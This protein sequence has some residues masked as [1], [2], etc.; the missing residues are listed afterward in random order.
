MNI[1]LEYFAI[2]RLFLLVG[3]DKFIEV[4]RALYP[5]LGLYSY[6]YS[7]LESKEF[8]LKFRGIYGDVVVDWE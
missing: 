5:K 1:Q 7:W 8:I 4:F 6:S 3:A 2:R